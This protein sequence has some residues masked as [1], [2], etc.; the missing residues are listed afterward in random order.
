MILRCAWVV[1]AVLKRFADGRHQKI[2]TEWLVQY[3]IAAAV[4]GNESGLKQYCNGWILLLGAVRKLNSSEA[5]GQL[6]V[7]QQ[8]VWPRAAFENRSGLISGLGG[9][10]PKSRSP[11]RSLHDRAE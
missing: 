1:C 4:A 3:S 10:D 5:S 8:H 11:K 7:A 2:W 6:D 9:G